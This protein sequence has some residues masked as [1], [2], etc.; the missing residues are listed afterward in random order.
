M[1]S[2]NRYMR[3]C[4]Q[5]L[6]NTGFTIPRSAFPVHYR[7][8]P[9]FHR[10][11]SAAAY[12]PEWRDTCAIRLIAFSQRTGGAVFRSGMLEIIDAMAVDLTAGMAGQFFSLQTAI[13]LFV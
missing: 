4:T 3:F 8:W 9:S 5:M 1:R 6:E 2:V 13:H 10:S 7:S 12:P 11:G